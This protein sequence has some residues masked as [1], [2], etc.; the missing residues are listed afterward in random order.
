MRESE[1]MGGLM[2]IYRH[3]YPACLGVCDDMGRHAGVPGADVHNDQL[4]G[5]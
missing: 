1:S 5:E 4:Q 3:I 2:N